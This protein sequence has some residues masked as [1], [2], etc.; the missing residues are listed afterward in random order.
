MGWMRCILACLNWF[1]SRRV[2]TLEVRQSVK[3]FVV[4]CS[5]NGEVSQGR[6]WLPIDQLSADRFP[7]RTPA[8][9]D[10]ARPEAA[11]SL[12][13]VRRIQSCVLVPAQSLFCRQNARRYR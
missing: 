2:A 7:D 10:L 12:G 5:W 8:L 13:Y 9:H 6:T 4:L 1:R 11:L 3:I